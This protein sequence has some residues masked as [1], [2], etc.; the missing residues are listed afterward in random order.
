MLTARVNSL[1]SAVFRAPFSHAINHRL[2]VS[3]SLSIPLC[4]FSPCIKLQI[5]SSSHL[6]RDKIPQLLS[7]IS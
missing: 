1:A 7:K 4:S 2:N 6:P 3:T 5:N